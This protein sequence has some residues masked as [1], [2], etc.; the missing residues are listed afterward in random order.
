[1]MDRANSIYTVLED[2]LP[3]LKGAIYINELPA[4]ATAGVLIKEGYSG[5]TI[6][7]EIRGLRKSRFQIAV[8]DSKKKYETAKRRAEAIMAALDIKGELRVTDGILIKMCR[9]L[10]EPIP[11]PVSDAGNIEFSLNFYIIYVV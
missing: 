10:T 9:P 5:A 2:R 7:P 4:S 8:R 3:D 1:M 6:D 11:Y